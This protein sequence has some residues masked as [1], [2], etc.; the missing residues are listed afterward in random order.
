MPGQGVRSRIQ[1]DG[2]VLLIAE[3]L[4]TIRTEIART[5]QCL[6]TTEMNQHDVATITDHLGRHLQEDTAYGM[7]ID[8]VPKALASLGVLI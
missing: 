5:D 3:H 1:E 8:L 6:T 7:I 4:E 2:L